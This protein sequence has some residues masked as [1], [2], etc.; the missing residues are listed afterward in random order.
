MLMPVAAVALGIGLPLAA[1]SD[2]SA[3]RFRHSDVR[4]WTV[5]SALAVMGFIAD[6]IGRRQLAFL[7]IACSLALA[8]AANQDTAAIFTT[9]TNPDHQAVSSGRRGSS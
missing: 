7:G 5:I 9:R 8:G 4:V 6:W 3:A 1:R 2:L